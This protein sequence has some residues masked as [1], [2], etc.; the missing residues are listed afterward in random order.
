MNDQR[1]GDENLAWSGYENI[2]GTDRVCPTLIV[3]FGCRP[4][5]GAGAETTRVIAQESDWRPGV[6]DEMNE[7]IE[8]RVGRRNVTMGLGL[9]GVQ[10]AN[11]DQVGGPPLP[12]KV[13]V[14]VRA[15]REIRL[16]GHVCV[17]RP[18]DTDAFDAARDSALLQGT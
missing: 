7:L 10:P 8:Y 11:C 3:H 9:V 5:L 14:E 12:T 13:M 17:L 15:R 16:V 4:W 6:S 1:G 2:A 18:S